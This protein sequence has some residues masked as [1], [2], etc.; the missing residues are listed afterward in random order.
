LKENDTKRTLIVNFFNAR[1]PFPQ[2]MDRLEIPRGGWRGLDYWK[3]DQYSRFLWLFLDLY[4]CI[5]FPDVEYHHDLVVAY[6]SRDKPKAKPR[7]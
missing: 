7:T 1:I 2:Q 5:D 4:R 3:C 6:T